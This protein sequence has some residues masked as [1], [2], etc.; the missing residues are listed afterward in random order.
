MIVL[1]ARYYYNDQIEK[2]GMGRVAFGTHGGNEEC[3]QDFGGKP[4]EK[5]LL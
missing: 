5:R 2:D 4:E 1:P 3:I